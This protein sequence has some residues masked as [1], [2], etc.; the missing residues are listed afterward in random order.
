MVF[1]VVW[2][3]LACFTFDVESFGV[4][5]TR[6]V[7]VAHTMLIDFV[8]LR[9]KH[10]AAPCCTE[11]CTV[12][13]CLSTHLAYCTVLTVSDTE[14]SSCMI[15]CGMSWYVDIRSRFC[16]LVGAANELCS[17]Y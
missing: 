5:G 7:A 10:C 2:V 9:L 16:L 11:M 6:H 17:I 4:L 3:R 15:R 13:F 8:I 14:L 12:E 1:G